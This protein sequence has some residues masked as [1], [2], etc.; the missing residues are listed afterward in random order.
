MFGD[1]RH[2]HS[3]SGAYRAGLKS[4][5]GGGPRPLFIALYKRRSLISMANAHLRRASWTRH[6]V[7]SSAAMHVVQYRLLGLLVAIC[8]YVMRRFS[9]AHRAFKGISECSFSNICQL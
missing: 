4:R 1:L 2:L 8:A 7:H 9:V 3:T 6:N 5:A